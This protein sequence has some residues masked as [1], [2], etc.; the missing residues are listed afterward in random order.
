MECILH[1]SQD[2]RANND[3][4]FPLA[5]LVQST[6]AFPFDL[7]PHL[8]TIRRSDRF[9]ISRQGLNLEMVSSGG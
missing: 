9:E 7:T 4:Q 5:E 1:S 2:P 6:A 3:R 8:A